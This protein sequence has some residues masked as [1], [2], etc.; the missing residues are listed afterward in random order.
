M[1]YGDRARLLPRQAQ[2]QQP[3]RLAGLRGLVDFRWEDAI[4][5]R[6]DLLQQIKAT[7]AGAGENKDGGPGYL[8]R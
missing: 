3:R 2:R 8:N 1:G 5:A 6:A 7:R 4:G